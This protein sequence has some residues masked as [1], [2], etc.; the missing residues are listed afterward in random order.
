MID[1]PQQVL[2]LDDPERMT[3]LLCVLGFLKS[4]NKEVVVTASFLRLCES[5]KLRDC[6]SESETLS[7]QRL[8]ERVDEQIRP[9]FESWR[10]LWVDV[11]DESLTNWE[12]GSLAQGGGENGKLTLLGLCGL[13][14]FLFLKGSFTYTGA[15]EFTRKTGSGEISYKKGASFQYKG[16]LS[17]ENSNLGTYL[18]ALSVFKSKN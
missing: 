13:G 15:V 7:S 11:F 3:I 16:P 14:I 18:D 12:Q 8:Y 10:S 2:S 1:I 4:E 17:N 6:G 5:L 9:R